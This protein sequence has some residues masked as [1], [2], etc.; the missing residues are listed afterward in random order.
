MTIT[1]NGTNGV[2]TP[3]LNNTAAES[4]ATTL[5]VT[6]AASIG[7]AATVGGNLTATGYVRGSGLTTNIYPIVLGTV[8]T[9]SS[10]TS[11]AFTSI[12]SWVTRITMTFVNVTPTASNTII[13]IGSASGS[14]KTTG[15]TSV[16]Q[17]V[18]SASGAA[19]TSTEGFSI[20]TSNG[21]VAS[22]QATLVRQTGDVW[23]C[24]HMLTYNDGGIGLGAGDVN[25]GADLDRI[26]LYS[27]TGT[28]TFSGNVNIM[29]E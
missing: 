11:K 25:L 29:Y 2:T 10:V 17:V 27:E 8:N 6:G 7:G 24:T 15:Y 21:Y 22:G 23:T 14:Y 26:R 12:P 19:Q 18:Y 3:G 28:P 4:V 5:T 1:L 9:S 20:Y 13:Q 16:G